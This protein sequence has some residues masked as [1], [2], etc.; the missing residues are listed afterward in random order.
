M[1]ELPE[2]ETVVRSLKPRLVGRRIVSFRSTWPRKV[3]P[4]ARAVAKRNAG[5]TVID[6]WRR[7]KW[8]VWDLDG[9]GHLLIHLR[10]SGR[11]E[12]ANGQ[13]TP[14]PHTR[15]TWTLDN[16]E[17]LLFV[18]PR[19]FGVIRHTRDVNAELGD[20]GIE[21]L[22]RTF[23]PRALQGLLARRKGRIKTILLDQTVI[24]GLGNIYV[25]E[26]LFAAGI[27]PE[28]RAADIRPEQISG[29]TRAIRA[30][31]REAIQRNGTSIDWI[32]PDGGMQDYLRVY[33]RAGEAC[34]RCGDVIA[35][36]VLGQ[37]GTHFCPTCQPVSRA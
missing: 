35:R 19:K 1:P 30:T 9:N 37:R 26:S 22:G 14:L 34:G 4:S 11:F 18:D 6:V 33:G 12:W 21:P 23:A 28:T 31:L 13:P 32:Y 10:M 2:V 24:A 8:I 3:F 17:T 25:D 27:H 15:A 20:L 36:I 5:A 7:G 29:L 16:S